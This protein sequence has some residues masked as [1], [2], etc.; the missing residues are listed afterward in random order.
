MTGKDTPLTRGRRV[1]GDREEKILK[2]LR[3]LIILLALRL[4]WGFAGVH[5]L[6]LLL[7]TE[8]MQGSYFHHQIP[9]KGLLGFKETVVTSSRGGTLTW[10]LEE[11]RRV[12]VGEAVARVVPPQ[13]GEYILK[14]PVAGLLSP[15]IDGL[16][17]LVYPHQGWVPQ[18]EVFSSLEPTPQGFAP[19]EEVP[20]G[21]PVFKIISNFTWYFTLVLPREEAALLEE[22]GGLM[23]EFDF[24]G[25]VYPVDH[26]VRHDMGEAH[27]FVTLSLSRDAGD[28][29]RRRWEEARLIYDRERSTIIPAGA[30]VEKD[31]VKGVYRL[32]RKTIIF[33]EIE[34]LGEQMD[35]EGLAVLG[36]EPGWE[37]VTNPRFFREGQ[38]F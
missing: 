27:E 24:S 7:K 8:V 21:S 29:Y 2:I 3:V 38:R 4:L 28:F 23:V 14:A 19:E 34:I 1:S 26:M 35:G 12:A 33:V 15:Y 6:S 5:V 13:G 16:E 18:K 10:L 20:P 31:G 17:G 30:V 25:E 37:I 36:L 11:G 32:A 22:G 9:V